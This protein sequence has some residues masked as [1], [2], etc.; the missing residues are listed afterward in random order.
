MFPLGLWKLA[1]LT[2][3][4]TGPPAGGVSREL[5]ESVTVVVVIA[6]AVTV[7]VPPPHAARARAAQTASGTAK[8]P[9]VAITVLEP[10]VPFEM[11][12]SGR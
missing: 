10:Y 3:W 8:D 6:G 5:A 11:E 2:L 7:F 4:V 1:S 9:R 12:P